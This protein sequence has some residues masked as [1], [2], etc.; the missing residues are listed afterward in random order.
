MKILTKITILSVLCSMFF[1]TACKK[2]AE[3]LVDEIYVVLPPEN[4]TTYTG[5]L[6]YTGNGQTL[7]DPLNG[8]A[9]IEQSGKIVSITFSN[10]VPSVTGI[11]FVKNGN[12]YV[13]VAENGSAAGISFTGNT[14]KIAVTKDG[15]NWGFS[16]SK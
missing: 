8:K 16:G 13:S 2:K 1:F 7:G 4:I 3:T 11:K 5:Q 14:V 12:D 10:S 15:G 6:A 9:T